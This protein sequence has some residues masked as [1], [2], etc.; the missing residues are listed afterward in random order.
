MAI[1]RYRR[2]GGPA[3]L[4]EVGQRH[5][6]PQHQGGVIARPSQIFCLQTLCISST[7]RRQRR[8]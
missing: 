6:G 7:V 4:S 1:A 2:Q 8:S 3:L 5:P